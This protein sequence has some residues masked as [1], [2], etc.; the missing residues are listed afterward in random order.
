VTGAPGQAESRSVA[1]NA[2]ARGVGEVVAKLASVAFFVAI[3]R[4]L[5]EGGFGDFM[6]A[7]SLATVLLLA[8]GFGTEDLVA[9]EVARD[10]SSLDDYLSNSIAVK[11]ATSVALLAFAA[12]FVNLAGYSA[13]T[14]VAVYLVG[15]GVAVEN[16]G[17]TLGSVFQAWERMDLLSV[18]LIVQRTATAGAGI[19]VLAAGGGILEVSLVFLGGSLLGFAVAALVLRR[20]VARPKLVVD[21]GRWGPILRAGA[22][23]GLVTMLFTVLLKLDQILI[24]FLSGGD[25][26]E[27]GYYAA[28]FRLVE[29]TMFISWSFAAAF[30]PWVARRGAEEAERLAQGYELALK[31]LTAVLLPIGVAFAILAAPLVDLFY[32]DPFEAAVEPLRWLGVMTLF[33]GLNM[34]A[35]T[36]LVAR[37]RPLDFARICGVVVVLN[38]ALNLALIP[39]F[40]ATGA[41]LAAALSSVALAL[42]GARRIAPLTGSLN[43]RRAFAGP[44]LAGAAMTAAMLIGS[45]SLAPELA[46]GAAVYLLVLYL[47]ERRLFPADFELARGLL[48]SGRGSPPEPATVAMES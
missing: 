27:V 46:L 44:V 11:V 10:R 29:A 39:P 45:L 23:I 5:G 35:S 6:F 28:A 17:R 47:L 43:V 21:R 37:D 3:A 42:L 1:R 19:A 12:A 16:L 33:Y 8:S 18:S 13:D 36:V 25:N 15:A 20:Y 7:L 26:R 9:R 4:E 41:A 22:P 48:R 24:S 32:G 2:V 40:G 31:A 14:R 38:L 34:L 30:L